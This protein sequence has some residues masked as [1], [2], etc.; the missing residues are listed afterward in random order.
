MVIILTQILIFKNMVYSP[1]KPAKSINQVQ[2][3]DSTIGIFSTKGGMS[4]KMIKGN[5]ISFFI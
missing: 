1:A 5:K 3:L 4:A 2:S